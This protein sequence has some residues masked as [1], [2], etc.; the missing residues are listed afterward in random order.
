M[1]R[2]TGQ[3]EDLEVSIK[4]KIDLIIEKKINFIAHYN[5]FG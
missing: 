3:D 1:K 5:R 2:P 4:G